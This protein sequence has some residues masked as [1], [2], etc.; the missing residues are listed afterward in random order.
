MDWQPVHCQ[1]CL[2]TTASLQPLLNTC[3]GQCTDEN[4]WVTHTQKQDQLTKKKARWTFGFCLFSLVQ[5]AALAQSRH[6]IS[7]WKYKLKFN[8]RTTTKLIAQVLLYS[9]YDLSARSS[10]DSSVNVQTIIC[11]WKK[12]KHSSR[13]SAVC[14]CK[15]NHSPHQTMPACLLH[16]LCFPDKNTPTAPVTL[17]LYL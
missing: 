14:L 11:S 15:L 13:L 1:H 10:G 17:L 3:S 9:L 2:F 4:D 6:K 16:S 8:V 7:C 12:V 5:W